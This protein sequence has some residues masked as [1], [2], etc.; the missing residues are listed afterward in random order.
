MR[1]PLIHFSEPEARALLAERALARQLE[2]LAG[3]IGEETFICSLRIYGMSREEAREVLAN[4]PAKRH[5][6]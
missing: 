5:A 2:F 1:S 6:Q 4:L 3:Q